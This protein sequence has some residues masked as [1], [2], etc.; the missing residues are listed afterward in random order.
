M[1]GTWSPRHVIGCRFKVDHDDG[2]NGC[3]GNAWRFGRWRVRLVQHRD[4]EHQTAHERGADDEGV[5]TAD[6]FDEEDDKGRA[7][8]D[9][10]DAEEAAQQ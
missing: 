4:D 5:A 3:G 2:C 8:D 9:F 6:A 7:G 10:G 1:V